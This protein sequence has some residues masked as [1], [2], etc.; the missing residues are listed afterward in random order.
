MTRGDYSEDLGALARQGSSAF[1][2]LAVLLPSLLGITLRAVVGRRRIAPAM[3]AFKLLNLLD[4]LVLNYTNVAAALPQAV[5]HPDWDFLALAFIITATMCAGA[6]A[7]GWW[8]PVLFHADR[9]DRIAL[10]FGLGMNNNGT[11]LVLAAAALAGRCRS[12]CC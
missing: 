4:L 1:V 8:I 11:G 2:V 7:A 6:F 5:A 10:T 3:P 12:C 9:A